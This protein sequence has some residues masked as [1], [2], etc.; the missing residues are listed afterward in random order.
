MAWRVEPAVLWKLCGIA[1]W[2][3]M[4]VRLAGTKALGKHCGISAET[5][6]MAG[7]TGSEDHG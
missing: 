7:D 5:T 2:L 6:A 3:N 4:C 1:S